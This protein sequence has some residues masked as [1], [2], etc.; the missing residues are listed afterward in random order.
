MSTYYRLKRTKLKTGAPGRLDEYIDRVL[1]KKINDHY[2]LKM[3]AHR[4]GDLVPYHSHSHS[5]LVIV[6]SGSIRFIIEEEI[7]D[8]T[9]GDIIEIQ[10]WAIHLAC[11]PDQEGAEFFICFPA[12]KKGSPER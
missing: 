4:H 6:E 3:V 5:E 12:R 7:V 9:K 1:N 8:L 10:P 11:F 2:H